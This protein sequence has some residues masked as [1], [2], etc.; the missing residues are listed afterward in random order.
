MKTNTKNEIKAKAKSETREK[1][2]AFLM[3]GVAQSEMGMA[4]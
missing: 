1:V 2:P 3:R 4:D